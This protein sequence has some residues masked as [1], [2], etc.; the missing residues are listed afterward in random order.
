MTNLKIIH[1]SDF[2]LG[3]SF[4]NFIGNNVEDARREDFYR[5][6][7]KVFDEAI[8]RK[9]DLLVISGDVFHR[10]DPAN[11][12]LIYISEQ[13]GRV[14]NN[15][16]KTV[17]IAGN[18]DKPK[19]A[20]ATNPL[21]ALMKAKLPNFYFIQSIPDKPLVINLNGKKVAII[22]VPYIDPRVIKGLGITYSNF[23]RRLL[24]KLKDNTP[25]DVDFKIL[26]GHLTL[27]GAK[28]KDIHGIY[29]NDPALSLDDILYREFDYVALGHVHTPQKIKENVYYAGSI[30]RIDFS[31]RDE[32]KSFLY[33]ELSNDIMVERIQLKCRDMIVTNK[34]DLINNKKPRDLIIKLLESMRIPP[35]SLL[36]IFM[37]IDEATWRVLE[38]YID[39]IRSYLLNNRKILGF[40]IHKEYPKPVR[41][42][43]LESVKIKSLRDII[44][45]YIA[46]MNIKEPVLKKRVMELAISLMD[47]VGLY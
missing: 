29:L 35:G 11:R 4:R 14:V 41:V 25:D 20:G 32:E 33:I 13:I 2:H 28:I 15:G 39:D 46:S 1:A 45:E 19:I 6:V 23:Y 37:K 10:S 7:K 5:N 12:D 40:M 24:N 44:L 36:R 31:E 22:P 9:V 34:I 8:S 18:H 3:V 16:I 17:I 30:E 47:E 42:N 21:L 26:V 27:S 38:R 43:S